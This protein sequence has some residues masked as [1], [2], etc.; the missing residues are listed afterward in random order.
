MSVDCPCQYFGCQSTD[1]DSC[2]I[3]VLGYKQKSG[4]KNI[5]QTY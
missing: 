3:Y 4:L 2:L 5:F 1:P